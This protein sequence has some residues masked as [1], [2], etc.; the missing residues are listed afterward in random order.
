MYGIP[1]NYPSWKYVKYGMSHFRWILSPSW[2]IGNVWNCRGNTSNLWKCTECVSSAIDIVLLL[3]WSNNAR[4]R[5]TFSVSLGLCEGIHH[6]PGFS[7]QRVMRT[8]DFSLMSFSTN[9]SVFWEA[10][11]VFDV[12]VY[13]LLSKCLHAEWKRSRQCETVSKF[14][15]L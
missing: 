1:S 8:Y 3:F 10:R 12:G 13:M 14:T 5:K 7:T 4:D 9:R 6:F 2:V 15:S 11:P